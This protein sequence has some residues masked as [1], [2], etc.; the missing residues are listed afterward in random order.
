MPSNRNGQTRGFQFRENNLFIE[1]S[2]SEVK[3]PKTIPKLNHSI[4]PQVAVNRFPE[5]QDVFNRSKLVPGELP[6]S[7]AV[8]STRLNSGKLNPIIIFWIAYFVKY[9]LVN[10][11]M[12]SKMATQNSKLSPFQIPE[13]SYTMLTQP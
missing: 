8:K 5:N 12:K 9:T 3:T 6:Y 10:L 13:K 7:N 4:R 11:I 1:A 2:R